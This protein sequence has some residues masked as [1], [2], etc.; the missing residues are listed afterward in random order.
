MSPRPAW[1]VRAASLLWLLAGAVGLAV[2]FASSGL[3]GTIL[4]A[5]T[6]VRPLAVLAT[7]PGQTAAILLCGGALYALRPG[8]TFQ[9][10]LM[11]RLLR[12]AGSNLLVFLPGLGEVIG[13]R[14][15]V[16]AGGRAR[17]A[18]TASVLDK[19]SE[20]VAQIPF[21][22][23]AVLLVPRLEITDHVSAASAD[24]TALWIAATCAVLGCLAVLAFNVSPAARTALHQGMTRLR[25]EVALL[26]GE[27]RSQRRG[28]LT[29]LGLH[30]VA[31]AMGG[32]QIWMVAQ[33]LS[34]PLDLFSAIVIESAAF[35][36]RGAAF[37][38]PA[39]LGVQEA[40]LVFA[41][42]A[43][44]LDPAQSIAIAL[45]L[46][47]RDVAFGVPLLAYPIFEMRRAR[48]SESSS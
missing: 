41:G 39:G 28:F 40:T 37:F 9:A 30:F 31:W 20:A 38:V 25:A 45:V 8:V 42:L 4:T 27:W 11:S 17:T 43:Y 21:A 34:F 26:G 10:S 44:G 14:A 24:A 13:A 46:R 3:R 18:V 1:R 23:L 35:A 7:L 47:L 48:P 22:V 2:A 36:V 5:L 19:V 32:V 6:H 29:A 15:L 12:D 16:L 33:A